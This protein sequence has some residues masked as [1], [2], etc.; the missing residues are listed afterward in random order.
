MLVF[1]AVMALC[2]PL[3]APIAIH[4]M[5]ETRPASICVAALGWFVIA[6]VI[7]GVFSSSFTSEHARGPIVQLS[8]SRRELFFPRTGRILP[9]DQVLRWDV[10]GGYWTK[11]RG[12]YDRPT[13]CEDERCELQLVLRD[14][15]SEP[16]LIPLL[17]G[18][19]P[20]LFDRQLCR[21]AIRLADETGRPTMYFS[22][23]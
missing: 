13:F 10:V 22:L 14:V 1:L 15:S 2:G 23:P 3:G 18:R 17:R 8:K 11:P 6:L 9:F 20:G 16:T 5:P 7:G 19:M 4:Y 21:A 12:R